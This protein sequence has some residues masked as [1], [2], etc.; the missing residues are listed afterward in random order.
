MACHSGRT[1][2]A[3][4][5]IENGADLNK[6]NHDGN[7]ALIWACKKGHTE[8]C[9]A[10]LSHA[11]ILPEL[12]VGKREFKANFLLVL[13]KYKCPKDMKFLLASKLELTEL[14]YFAN[15][16]GYCNQFKEAFLIKVNEIAEYTMEA[17][18]PMMVDAINQKGVTQELKNLLNPEHYEENFGELLRNNIKKVIEAKKLHLFMR[19]PKDS[20]SSEVTE[21]KEEELKRQ[22]GNPGLEQGISIPEE[23]ELAKEVASFWNKAKQNIPAI[24]SIAAIGGLVIYRYLSSSEQTTTEKSSEKSNLSSS[25]L[26]DKNKE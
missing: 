10:L 14:L 3:K 15:I 8:I 17:L 25:V 7:T 19:F 24:V 21:K 11:I 22:V 23:E 4:L 20:S 16:K 5:L 12:T 9:K 6:Q 13:K 1:E 18:M 26:K 2:I